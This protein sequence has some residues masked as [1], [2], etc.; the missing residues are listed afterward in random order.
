MFGICQPLYPILYLLTLLTLYTLS[1]SKSLQDILAKR[2]QNVKDVEV[3]ERTA[4]TNTPPASLSLGQNCPHFHSEELI[5][6]SDLN[7]GNFWWTNQNI[8]ADSGAYISLTEV[9]KSVFLRPSTA[10]ASPLVTPTHDYG[11]YSSSIHPD[12][13]S[14]L[15]FPISRNYEQLSQRSSIMSWNQ[16]CK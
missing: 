3:N 15:S 2:K 16:Q 12:Q 14:Y 11:W 5:S 4:Q 9:D 10:I 8:L 1:I 7:Q 6:S 13:E